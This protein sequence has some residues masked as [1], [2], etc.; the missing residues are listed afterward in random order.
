M[1]DGRRSAALPAFPGTGGGFH[2]PRARSERRLRRRFPAGSRRSRAHGRP[3][4]QAGQRGDGPRGRGN[5]RGPGV[6]RQLHQQLVQRPDEG[7]RDP[8]RPPDRGEREPAGH[9]RHKAEL[10]GAAPERSR[11][12][13]RAGRRARAGMRLRPLRGHGPGRAHGRRI[14]AHGKPQFQGALRHQGIERLHCRSRNGGLY[15]HCRKDR[16]GRG[17]F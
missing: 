3:A 5:R 6:H 15:R 8:A 14:P 13:L 9:P 12:S 17:G 7:R 1:P 16:L 10:P 4:A 11:G 2:R